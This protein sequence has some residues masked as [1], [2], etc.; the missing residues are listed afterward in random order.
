[1]D[2]EIRYPDYVSGVEKPFVVH[3]PFNLSGDH[4][5]RAINR[6]ITVT[7]ADNCMISSSV[8]Q[9]NS[10]FPILKIQINLFNKFTAEFS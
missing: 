5:V 4:T 9:K 3:A 6:L 2:S 10:L 7:T 1:M 8:E